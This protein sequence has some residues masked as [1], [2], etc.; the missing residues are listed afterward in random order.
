MI[1]KQ[2]P[3]S[4]RHFAFKKSTEDFSLLKIVNAIAFI[5][6]DTFSTY[7]SLCSGGKI[8]NISKNTFITESTFYQTTSSLQ[9]H[10]FRLTR[11]KRGVTFLN[12][13]RHKWCNQM[14]LNRYN[15]MEFSSQLKLPGL[16]GQKW[17]LPLAKTDSY[18]VYTFILVQIVRI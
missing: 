17:I 1:Q 3:K 7:F 16:Y 8:H 14:V 6:I 11:S 2:F 18:I 5:I 15:F 9:H 4:T 10:S 12:I 13:G